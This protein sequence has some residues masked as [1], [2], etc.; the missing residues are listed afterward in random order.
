MAEQDEINEEDEMDDLDELNELYRVDE[1]SY[2]RLK[3]EWM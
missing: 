1:Y 2:P 3:L